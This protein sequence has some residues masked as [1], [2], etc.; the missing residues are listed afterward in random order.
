MRVREF[1]P[2]LKRAKVRKTPCMHKPVSLSSTLTLLVEASGYRACMLG[3]SGVEG[4]AFLA[5]VVP[6]EGQ[7]DAVHA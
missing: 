4:Q 1:W 2:L 6:C 3:R 7:E 5:V